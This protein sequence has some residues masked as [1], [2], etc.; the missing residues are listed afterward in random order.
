MKR[1]ALTFCAAGLLLLS[2]NN[3]ADDKTKT[4]NAMSADTSKKTAAV[5]SE[6]PAAAAP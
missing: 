2:C 3:N 4:D 6:T 5:K 1:I